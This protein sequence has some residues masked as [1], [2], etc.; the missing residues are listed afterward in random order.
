MRCCVVLDAG[1]VGE[2]EE[3]LWGLVA[4]SDDVGIQVFYI[5]QFVPQG[6]QLEVHLQRLVEGVL[7]GE[8]HRCGC[9]IIDVGDCR[10]LSL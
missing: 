9:D 3:L 8:F 2:Q 7:C 6:A 5:L 10:V 4:R 1:V